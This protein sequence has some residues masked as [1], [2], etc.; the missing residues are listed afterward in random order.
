MSAPT[1]PKAFTFDPIAHR[2]R[3]GASGRFL[4]SNA[5]HGY[6]VDYSVNVGASM[7]DLTQQLRQGAL[8]VAEWQVRV[9]AEIK[10]AHVAAAIAAAGGRD[11]MT[12]SLWGATGQRIKTE[13]Q[14]LSAF[15]D[16][17][18]SG[19]IPM[20]GHV[21]DRTA[22]YGR[23]ARETYW[24]IMSREMVRRGL[25]EERNVLD[26]SEHEVCAGCLDATALEWQRVGTIQPVGSRVP[27]RA[28]CLCSMQY[29]NSATGEVR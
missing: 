25:D 17:I 20:D 5:V 1:R 6:V 10:S 7:R 26:P 4:S 15:A 22:Q 9:A 24:R 18:A 19:A 27:C 21:L 12:P 11:Q 14:F 16:G 8:S 2:Y 13:Y 3:D 23:D 29:R 28:N